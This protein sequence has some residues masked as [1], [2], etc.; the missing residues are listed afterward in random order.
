VHQRLSD[1]RRKRQATDFN[2]GRPGNGI[3][4]AGS[5][6]RHM[7]LLGVVAQ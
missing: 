6:N 2:V 7:P 1:F 5:L 4:M 3:G